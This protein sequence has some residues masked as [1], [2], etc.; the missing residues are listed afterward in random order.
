MSLSLEATRAFRFGSATES[1]YNW[2]LLDNPPV[3]QQE[4]YQSVAEYAGLLGLNLDPYSNAVHD[5]SSF[6]DNLMQTIDYYRPDLTDAFM[7][8][9]TATRLI[10]LSLID[11]KDSAEWR[12]LWENTAQG[13]LFGASRLQIPEQKMKDWIN[14]VQDNPREPNLIRQLEQ[15]S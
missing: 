4:V 1:F 14:K 9:R 6:L 5:P 11:D 13:V 10:V 12:D 3:S 15:A 2:N 7:L 8:G